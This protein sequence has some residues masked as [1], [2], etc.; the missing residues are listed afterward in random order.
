MYITC[1]N[2]AIRQKPGSIYKYYST[3]Q[4]VIVRYIILLG[5]NPL[6]SNLGEGL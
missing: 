6:M 1:Q 5:L 4:A 2:L 3:H